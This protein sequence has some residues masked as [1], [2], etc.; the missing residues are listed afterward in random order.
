MRIVIARRKRGRW[1]TVRSLSRRA[2]K[3]V[4]RFRLGRLRRKGR[5]RIRVRAT[6]ASGNRSR[7]R[8]VRF[9]IRR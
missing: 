4:N 8:A 9:R 7:R 2:R 1:R 3:G 6:D 5:Y